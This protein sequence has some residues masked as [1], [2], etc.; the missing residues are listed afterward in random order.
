MSTLY[1]C[2]TCGAYDMK[3]EDL[4]SRCVFNATQE[5]PAEYEFHCPECGSTVGL[6][7]QHNG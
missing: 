6:E 7:E 5:E 4:D 2:N 3:Q 1:N